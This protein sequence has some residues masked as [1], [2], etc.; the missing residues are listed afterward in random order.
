MRWNGNLDM[1]GQQIGQ[2]VLVQ[3]VFQNLS[4]A[5]MPLSGGQVY[6]D[7]TSKT[8]WFYDGTEWK[9]VG[10]GSGSGA[11]WLG[12][13]PADPLPAD[14][15]EGDL[16]FNTTTDHLRQFN[17]TA[18]SNVATDSGGAAISQVTVDQFTPDDTNIVTQ[19]TLWTLVSAVRFPG[20]SPGTVYF[21]FYSSPAW[22][23]TKDLQVSLAYSLSSSVPDGKVKLNLSYWVPSN[24]DV[25]NPAT[26]T[27][28]SEDTLAV[29][30]TG[31]Q[32]QQ[33]TT[34]MKF[35]KDHITS[36]RQVVFGKL[37]RDIVVDGNHPGGF[38]LIKFVVH[39]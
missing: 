32:F 21:S 7:T 25:P 35:S 38:D 5:P 9:Q 31:N 11:G 15:H 39:Q 30:A 4:S 8:L 1:G 2:A 17:G 12:P 22:D 27:G 33:L 23:F 20:G 29:V 10:S 13:R 19:V 16:Y 6:F 14:S 26:P 18:W 36:G 34:A 28:S 3:P 37:T 24:G